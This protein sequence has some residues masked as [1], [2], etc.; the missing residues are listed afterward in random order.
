[1]YNAIPSARARSRV[2]VYICSIYLA[3]V[4]TYPWKYILLY[5][6]EVVVGEAVGGSDTRE[7]LWV[8]KY[9]II[10]TMGNAFL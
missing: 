2:C 10:F 3:N 6:I 5:E 4:Y 7:C 1:V 8:Q 9:D